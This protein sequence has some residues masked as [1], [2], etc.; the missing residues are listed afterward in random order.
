MSDPVKHDGSGCAFIVFYLLPAVLVTFGLYK[1]GKMPFWG[2]LG[3]GLGWPL[4]ILDM[5]IEWVITK[6]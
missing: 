5:F 6:Q 1:S 3:S 2:S 4:G